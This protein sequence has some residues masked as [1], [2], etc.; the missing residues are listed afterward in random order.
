MII[1]TKTFVPHQPYD[2]DPFLKVTA[3]ISFV[4]LSPALIW[5]D[6]CN[7]LTCHNYCYMFHG[8]FIHM[9]QLKFVGHLWIFAH[10]HLFLFSHSKLSFMTIWSY[11]FI[12]TAI[13][14]LH[15]TKLHSMVGIG[16]RNFHVNMETGQSHEATGE[17]FNILC[18][19]TKHVNNY[20][21]FEVIFLHNIHMT[22]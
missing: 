10:W 7:Y 8:H 6:T 22:T 21:D 11:V 3:A 9:T 19:S 20:K 13:F 14:C 17:E 16:L 12:V 18:L 15:F 5:T 2:L 4:T 1:L